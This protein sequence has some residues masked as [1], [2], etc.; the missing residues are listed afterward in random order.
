MIKSERK[1][2][3]WFRFSSKKK[4][5]KLQNKFSIFHF[6]IF[7]YLP[8]LLGKALLTEQRRVVEVERKL[9][10]LLLFGSSSSSSS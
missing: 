9:R 8:L 7:L 5:L 2:D 1:R 6:S 10:L 3:S 4:N